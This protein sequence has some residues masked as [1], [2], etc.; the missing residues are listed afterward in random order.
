[1]RTQLQ[2]IAQNKATSTSNFVV[3]T[4]KY[5]QQIRTIISILVCSHDIPLTTKFLQVLNKIFEYR[6]L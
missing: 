5:N 1:M 6:S 3:P 4:T 2:V